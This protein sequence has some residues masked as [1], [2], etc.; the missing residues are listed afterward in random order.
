MLID[1]QQHRG[2][3]EATAR[4][5][6]SVIEIPSQ[7]RRPEVESGTRLRT[8]LA[9]F[10]WVIVPKQDNSTDKVRPFTPSVSHLNGPSVVFPPS[11]SRGRRSIFW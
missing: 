1:D 3:V 4:R 2:E 6:Q 11:S 7:D 8:F 9:V 10:H 5:M